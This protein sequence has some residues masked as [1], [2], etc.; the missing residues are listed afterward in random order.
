[1]AIGLSLL[2]A[3][4]HGGLY[5]GSAECTTCDGLDASVDVAGGRSLDATDRSVPAPLDASEDATVETSAE[6]SVEASADVADFADVVTDAADGSVDAAPDVLSDAAADASDGGCGPLDTVLNCSACGA[7][8]DAANSLSPSCN[9]TTCLY[10]A[11]A[12]GWADCTKSAPD[13][14]G[15]ETATNTATNCSACGLAC[16]TRNSLSAT[17]D[18][19]TCLYQACASGFANCTTTAP[20]LNGCETPTTTT[21][22]CGGCGNVCDKTSGTPT[23]NGTTCAYACNPGRSDCSQTPPDLNGCECATP[24]CCGSSCQYTHIDGLGQDFYDCVAP[25][26]Y[27]LAQAT[28]ACTAFTGNAS[29]CAA[30]SCKNGAGAVCSATSPTSCACWEYSGSATGHVHSS[31]SAG[32]CYCALVTDTAWD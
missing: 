29:Q 1:M 17:C 13:V 8:C 25:G 23:C 4:A 24:G 26:V 2:C 20:D 19:T 6:A 5:D 11:C 10:Q 16:D 28:E 15:C 27:D 18:G 3:C 7:A 32:Q 31:G 12:T 9:G 22:N 21:A 30:I 14:D